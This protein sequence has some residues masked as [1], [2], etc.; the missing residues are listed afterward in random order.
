MGP[1]TKKIET[2]FCSFLKSFDKKKTSSRSTVPKKGKQITVDS[3]LLVV[4]KMTEKPR[5]II[6]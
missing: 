5:C 6:Y 1:L 4:V 3:I 2:G